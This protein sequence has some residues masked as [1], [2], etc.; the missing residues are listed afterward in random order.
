M[1]AYDV[2][3]HMLSQWHGQPATY[4]RINPPSH[5]WDRG[6]FLSFTLPMRLSVTRYTGLT[7]IT[8]HER[9]AVEYGPVLLA[10]VGGPWNETLDSML[11]PRV[12]DPED[13]TTWLQPVPHSPLHFRLRNGAGN[14][15]WKPYY[16]VQDELFE[17]YP[18]FSP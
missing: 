10:V 9:F 6:I 5:G 16:E 7:V 17:V 14:L 18:A 1:T 3:G 4:L 2:S 12:A 8:G 15:T 13:A 11:V